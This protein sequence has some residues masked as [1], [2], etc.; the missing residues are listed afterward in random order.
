MKQSKIARTLHAAKLIASSPFNIIKRNLNKKPF[1]P[2]QIVFS[3]TDQCNSKC[4]H[5]N[6]WNKKSPKKE[7][8]P[9]DIEKIF[10]DVLFEH[11]EGVILSGGEISLR[12]D[13][14]NFMLAI[15]K[16]HPE[17]DIWISTNALLPDKIITLVREILKYDYKIGVGISLDG[18]GKKHDKIR[19]V[20]GNFKKVDYLIKEL[21]NMQKSYFKLGIAIGFTLSDKT[22]ENLDDVKKYAEKYC[23]SFTPQIAEEA[24]FYGNIGESKIKYKRKM[25]KALKSLKDT[26][27]RYLCINHFQNKKI[28]FPCFSLNKFFLLQCNGDINP[29]LK[30]SDIVVGNLKEEP[31][32]KIW[33][34]KRTE[35]IREKIKN[36]KGCLNTWAWDWSVHSYCFP[37]IIYKLKKFFK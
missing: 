22:V 14:K 13:L 18:I 25:I 15:Y 36:C 35:R 9:D 20:P 34:S 8:I 33:N 28:K 37:L 5:C 27:H 19:G 1:K 17:I 23:V 21:K 2:K 3:I 26:P 11:L 16:N 4:V 7:L 29:C 32:S 12:N 10:S 30:L 31:L 6:I 24:P